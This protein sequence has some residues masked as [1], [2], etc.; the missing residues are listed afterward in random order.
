MAEDKLN[1]DI[2]VFWS[3]HQRDEE[4]TDF[5]CAVCSSEV[6]LYD[7][8]MTQHIM[9]VPENI[10]DTFFCDAEY[11]FCVPCFD[12]LYDRIDENTD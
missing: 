9:F 12:K 2:R 5:I 6:G 3:E 11:I 1:Y 8:L 7:A 10:V 4:D